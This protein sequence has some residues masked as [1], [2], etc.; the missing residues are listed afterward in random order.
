MGT[1]IRWKYWSYWPQGKII[2]KLKDTDVVGRPDPWLLQGS[3]AWEMRKALRCSSWRSSRRRRRKLG[4]VCHL[5]AD[6]SKSFRQEGPAVSS[7]TSRSWLMGRGGFPWHF[8]VRR[9]LLLLTRAVWWDGGYRTL[10]GMIQRRIRGGVLETRK[11]DNSLRAFYCKYN[12][13]TW[14]SVPRPDGERSSVSWRWFC[15]PFKQGEAVSSTCA[16]TEGGGN[17]ENGGG[18]GGAWW[19]GV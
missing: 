1:R 4:S 5:E 3:D 18:R 12:M 2:K 17:P 8:M 16:V 19:S 9:S 15:F 11:T 6:S 7:A 10:T 13:E 14:S